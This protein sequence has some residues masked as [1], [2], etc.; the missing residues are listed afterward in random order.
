MNESAL[1]CSGVSEIASKLSAALEAVQYGAYPSYHHSLRDATLLIQIV[2]LVVGL[3]TTDP[4]WLFTPS[5]SECCNHPG[6]S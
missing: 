2:Y 4:C 6:G 3:F 1:L 5:Q